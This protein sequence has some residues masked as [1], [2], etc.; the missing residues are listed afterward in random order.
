MASTRERLSASGKRFY[1][2][3]VSRGR[4]KSTLSEN[5]YVPDGWS[6]KSIQRELAKVA[7]EF[8]RRVKNGEVISRT[9]KAEIAASEA[10]E[11][12]KIKTFKLYTEEVYIP[13]RR[14]MGR[15]K[16][17]LYKD[18]CLLK[19]HIYPVIGDI[20]LSEISAAMIKSLLIAM[21][22]KGYDVKLVLQVYTVIGGVM[23]AAYLDDSIEKNPMDK[24]QRP[25]PRKDEGK[26]EGAEFYSR[27]EL[28]VILSCAD[29]EPLKWQTL[30]YLL[31]FTGL[32]IGEALALTRNSIDFKNHLITIDASMT[33]I[34]KKGLS[35]DTTKNG[36][37]RIIPLPDVLEPL[38]KKMISS[39]TILKAS[40]EKSDYIFTQE[41]STEPLHH[42]SA[43]T[44][45][46]R[47]GKKYGIEGFHCHKLRHPYVKKTQKFQFP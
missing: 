26:K 41:N 28:R 11:R 40:A 31:A 29:K 20:K 43:K 35:R 27:D 14:S 6:E 8:E 46:Y 23:K 38:L 37:E 30:I 22:E 45:F 5:W 15:A 7:A 19:N 2:I 32:R 44:Y 24:V 13:S 25:Q 18:G 10:E 42:D 3:R 12:A 47:F 21:Q 9:E 4:G 17:T 33:Y 16:S 34:P 39:K 1:E 36:K